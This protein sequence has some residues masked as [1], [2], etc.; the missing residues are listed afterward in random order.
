MLLSG[1]NS[2]PTDLGSVFG[3]L[4]RRGEEKYDCHDDKTRSV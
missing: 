4:P 2:S 1:R 3:F